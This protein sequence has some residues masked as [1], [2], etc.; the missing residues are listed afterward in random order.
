MA[1]TGSRRKPEAAPAPPLAFPRI[2]HEVRRARW[3]RLRL[4]L[5]W[6]GDPTVDLTEVRAR[7]AAVAGVETVR[8]S[9]RAHCVTVIYAAAPAALAGA[10]ATVLRT[11]AALRPEDLKGPGLDPN[12]RADASA[13]A[14]LTAAVAAAL[15]PFLPLPLRRVLVLASVAPTLARG[16]EALVRRG[17]SVEVL[18]AV[19]VAVPALRGRTGT[20]ATTGLLLSFAQYVE[21]RAS[22]RSDDLVRSLLRSAPER[23][24][25][26]HEGGGEIELPYAD[27]KL[28]DRVIVGPG[29]TV[30]VDGAV[31]DGS[32]TLD[33][34]A[35]TGESIPVPVEPG[36]P[37]TSGALLLE[38]RLVVAAERVGDATTTARIAR[39]IEKTLTGRSSLQSLADRMADR[40]VWITFGTAGAVYALTG[41]L[42]RVETISLVDFS[43]T[44]KLGTAVSIKAALYRAGRHGLL[45][46]GGDALDALAQADT[47]VFDKT[48]TLT[49]GRLKV[50]EVVSFRRGWPRDRLLA[51]AG[52]LSEHTT[53]PV[54]ASLA[55]LMRARDL[56]HIGHEEVEFVVGHGLGSTVDGKRILLGSHHFLA[57]H[58]DVDFSRWTARLDALSRSGHSL[59]YLSADGAPLG[60]IAL[61]DQVRGEA[62]AVLARLRRLGVER[63]VMITGDR[64][65]NAQ[66][67]GRELGLD[68]VFAEAQPEEKAGILDKL[69][70]GG[71]RVAFVGDGVNDGP[72]LMAADVGI[73]MPRAAEIARATADVVL[74]DDRLERVADAVAL[75][76]A[77]LAHLRR[78][79]NGA[80]AV[81]TAVLAGAAM[82]RLAPL[83]AAVLHNGT[84]LAVLAASWFGVRAIRP[85]G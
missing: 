59:L 68:A 33:S 58:H 47:L 30:P 76:Q 6:L 34:S 16:A 48:G 4:R 14:L 32:G 79:L 52:S 3:G 75:S 51:L 31:A 69:R 57:D 49:T 62:P 37:V 36:D 55:E 20:A 27:L 9:P 29:E 38:G 26:Q 50:E 64:R 2:V 43:C 1:T 70:T 53:H 22:Q 60:V 63:L 74:L 67:L 42:G 15:V 13:T 18:D 77:T 17:I 80:A 41:S 71:R 78:V 56:G 84:T 83:P 73:A 28:G 82:G 81:N 72:A 61:R 66:R 39:F 40:R 8:L 65:E 24:W 54:A 11:V 7:L 12:V 45:L 5:L 35:I 46:K 44:T 21:Q 23:V 25:V 10:R 85:K 19:A